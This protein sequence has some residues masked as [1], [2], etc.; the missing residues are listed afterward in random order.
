M[1]VRRGLHHT[2]ESRCNV[3]QYGPFLFVLPALSVVVF[4]YSKSSI[5]NK[6]EL[7]S[8]DCF[9]MRGPYYQTGTSSLWNT[10]INLFS[11]KWG[12]TSPKRNIILSSQPQTH[13][14]FAGHT[15]SLKSERE[16]H[17]A[18]NSGQ[19]MA[20]SHESTQGNRLDTFSFFFIAL[21][22]KYLPPLQLMI[23][24]PVTCIYSVVVTWIEL[25]AF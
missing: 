20:A 23:L 19:L 11:M 5:C 1:P 16:K 10:T 2:L 13:C 12:K 4:A 22:V 3:V 21:N 15:L 17:A 9:L 14:T 18:A 6:Q 25:L 24:R 7:M 8:K